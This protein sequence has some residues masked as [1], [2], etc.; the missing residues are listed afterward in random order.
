MPPSLQSF[1]PPVLPSQSYLVDIYS[2]LGS[3]IKAFSV[4]K[5]LASSGV[6]LTNNAIRFVAVWLAQP[7]LITGIAFYSKV[8]GV[9]TG[10]N[11]NRLAL[12][13][14]S[15]GTQTRV[16][17][18]ANDETIWKNT[19]NTFVQVP[20][21]ATYSAAK[22]LYFVGIIY[23]NSAQTTAPQIDMTAIG[24]PNGT[25]SNVLFSNSAFTTGQ[26]TAQNTMPSSIAINTITPV[27]GVPWVALY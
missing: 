22:G 12:F 27:T 7:S 6:N 14:Y 9:F 19:A 8:A 11:E 3:P 18:T 15:A 21:T 17:I 10:N 25:Q 4:D 26:I 2:A 20:F 23:N 13:S 5:V 16:A 24:T 1:I